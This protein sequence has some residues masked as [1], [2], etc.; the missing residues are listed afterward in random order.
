MRLGY[1]LGLWRQLE[2]PHAGSH[3]ETESWQ[4]KIALLSAASATENPTHG[5]TPSDLLALVLAVCQTW[6]LAPDAVSTDK[7]SPERRQV[8]VD[9]VARLLC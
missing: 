1:K 7:T 3:G 4:Q 9:A 2:R 5:F 8:I 6:H